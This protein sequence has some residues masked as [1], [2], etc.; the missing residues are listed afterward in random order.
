MGNVRLSIKEGT[1]RRVIVLAVL[2]SS[3]LVLAQ[4][5][6]NFKL[7]EHTFNSGGTPSQGVQLTSVSFSVTLASIGDTV[8]ATGLSSTSFEAD[9]G[10]DVAYPPVVV[11]RK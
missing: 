1:I 11:Q 8:V 6:T 5:S 3:G 9:V 2:L 10:F 7:E 4:T